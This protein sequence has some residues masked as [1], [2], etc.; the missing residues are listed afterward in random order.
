MKEFKIANKFRKNFTFDKG[1]LI[2]L[3]DGEKLI[4][5]TSIPNCNVSYK[6]FNS[7]IIIEKGLKIAK[8]NLVIGENAF[9]AFGRNFTVRFNI[10]LDARATNSTIVFGHNC[11]IGTVS[12]YSGDEP[13]L[14]IIVGDEFLSAHDLMLRNSD[15]H[16]ICD[17][18]T[19]RPLNKPNFGIHIGNHVWCGY[20]TS[21][22]KD[23]SIPDN[24]VVAACAVVGKRDFSPN[25]IIGGIPAKTI[26]ANIEWHSVTVD[27]FIQ[28]NPELIENWGD[29]NGSN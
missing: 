20:R 8:G 15:G 2:F 27:K 24:C 21:I 13:N 7:I 28:M 12:I 25:S 3:K 18:T 17:L 14:E 19:H 16:T 9:I 26:K 11:N 6:G 5:Q 1:N 10:N 23:A 22:L 29:Q 4:P